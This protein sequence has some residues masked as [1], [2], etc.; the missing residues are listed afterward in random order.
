MAVVMSLNNRLLSEQRIV[1]ARSVIVDE[2][3]QGY[4]RIHATISYRVLHG[5]VEKLRLAIP[6][7]FEVTKAESVLLAR[8]EVKTD[9]ADVKTL[10]A[11]LREPTSEQIVL[12]VTANRS[13]GAAADWLAGLADWKFPHLSRSIQPGKSRWW[14]LWRRID[15]GRKT[16]RPRACCRSTQPAS[17][18]RF[19]RACVRR[20]PAHRPSGRS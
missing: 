12:H 6:T 20:S 10:E 1:V 19:P 7:G 14:A 3:T 18:P 13:P 8:W 2:I 17:P 5:A 16:S 15:C 4:E 11:T 9:A